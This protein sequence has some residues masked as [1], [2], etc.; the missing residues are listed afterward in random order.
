MLPTAALSSL[1]ACLLCLC[2]DSRPVW[3]EVSPGAHR[4]RR[5]HF[6]LTVSSMT[7]VLCLRVGF[8]VG[9]G[10]VLVLY[11]FFFFFDY[12]PLCWTEWRLVDRLIPQVRRVMLFM[13]KFQSA[14][15]LNFAGESSSNDYAEL[16]H[17]GVMLFWIQHVMQMCLW[18]VVVSEKGRKIQKWEIMKYRPPCSWTVEEDRSLCRREFEP[19]SFDFPHP[20]WK[21]QH[22]K[23]TL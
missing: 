17:T 6:R 22:F 10:K 4:R 18:D 23:I 12:S 20:Q 9:D 1:A 7:C 5:S 16:K 13:Q 3:Q 21:R 15:T 19:E 14:H 2:S 8:D 11:L